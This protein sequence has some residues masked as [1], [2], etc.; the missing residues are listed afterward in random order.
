MANDKAI[1]MEAANQRTKLVQ[2]PLE[3]VREVMD[4]CSSSPVPD[5]WIR[6]NDHWDP[7]R[8]GSPSSLVYNVCT[9]ERYNNKRICFMFWAIDDG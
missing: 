6:V 2:L 3:S 7:T 4:I 8:C 9:I 1:E 5:G